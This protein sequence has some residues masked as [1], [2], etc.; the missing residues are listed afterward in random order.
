V[1]AVARRSLSSRRGEGQREGGTGMDLRAKSVREPAGPEDGLRLLVMRFWPRG[2]SQSSVEAWDRRFAPS[3]KLLLS[4]RSG[5][6]TWREFAGLYVGEMWAQARLLR[7]IGERA[8]Q[9]RVTLLCQCGDGQRCHRELIAAIVRR[10]FA[11]ASRP[12]LARMAAAA[13]STH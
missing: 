6:I 10:M 3:A 9:R 8:Q 4:Y 11:R 1:G 12:A 2:V 13:A 5:R 7:E